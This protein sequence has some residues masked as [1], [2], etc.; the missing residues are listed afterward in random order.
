MLVAQNSLGPVCPVPLTVRG[1]L[2]GVAGKGRRPGHSA[3]R[4]QSTTRKTR[5]RAALR[6]VPRRRRG[7]GRL[8][9]ER[10]FVLVRVDA[11]ARL[12]LLV[13]HALCGERSLAP[14]EVR[15]RQGLQGQES[16]IRSARVHQIPPRNGAADLAAAAP[17]EARPVPEQR[18]AVTVPFSVY[19]VDRHTD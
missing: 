12:R 17:V 6:A 18:R 3:L 5:V 14:D 8:L 13:P 15:A 2:R 1:S 4:G 19:R 16:F 7:R 10:E 9:Q 11:E